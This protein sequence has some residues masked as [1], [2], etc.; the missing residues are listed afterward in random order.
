MHELPLH[1]LLQTSYRISQQRRV[2]LTDLA[3]DVIDSDP[4]KIWQVPALDLIRFSSDLH[5]PPG[6]SQSK[7]VGT[8]KTPFT[9]PESEWPALAAVLP[10]EPAKGRHGCMLSLSQQVMTGQPLQD[11]PHIRLHHAFSWM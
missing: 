4:G 2:L 6:C 3:L 5:L 8:R 10:P 11:D 1:G 9:V 7:P